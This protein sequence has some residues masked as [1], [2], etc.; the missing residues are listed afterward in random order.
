MIARILDELRASERFSVVHLPFRFTKNIQQ[1]RRGGFGKV[2]EVFAVLIRL[3]RIRSSGAIDLL[4]YP[5]GGPQLVPL[6]RDLCLLPWMILVAKKTCLHFHAG[7]IAE[8]IDKQPFIVRHLV[9]WLYRKSSL[10]IVMT[11][12]GKRDPR[13]VGIEQIEVVPN[14]LEDRYDEHTL[15]RNTGRLPR[16][17]YVGHFSEEKGTPSL[18]QAV[19]M[20]RDSGRN[21]LLTLIGEAVPP[22]T[23][24]DLQSVI[25]RLGLQSTVRGCGVLS[26]QEKWNQFA[27]A[28]LF[29]FPSLAAES[30]G[31]SMVEAM[32]W[33]L[34]VVACDWRG[35]REVLSDEFG[36]ILFQPSENLS[37]ALTK[38]LEDTLAQRHQWKAWGLR[39]R[40]TFLERYKMGGRKSPLAAVLERSMGI[41]NEGQ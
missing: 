1:T 15:N 24:A 38:A 37:T 3:I 14:T 21:C 40:K 18:L 27:E 2:A 19:A 29:V 35:N 6:I 12:F 31:L 36:G 9:R 34:P 20:L 26:G 41:R 39:N 22:Y 8:T 33:A 16:L 10:A 17:L 11:Q 7:G 4:L 25:E 13:S 28:D 32:M 23:D 5:V 30:F